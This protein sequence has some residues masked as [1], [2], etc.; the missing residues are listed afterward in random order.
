MGIKMSYYVSVDLNFIVINLGSTYTSSPKFAIEMELRHWR[1]GDNLSNYVNLG[2]V[3]K[4]TR[5]YSPSYNS[6]YKL[7][8]VEIVDK[9]LVKREFIINDE[10]LSVDG[11]VFCGREYIKNIVSENDHVGCYNIQPNAESH[12]YG[13]LHSLSQL[14]GVNLI[15]NEAAKCITSTFFNNVKYYS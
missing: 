9:K 15:E 6:N 12:A 2:D 13:L 10:S 7:A 8:V 11:E 3:V 14:T 1:Y 4:V 5:L